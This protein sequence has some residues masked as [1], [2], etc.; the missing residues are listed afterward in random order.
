MRSKFIYIIIFLALLLCSCEKLYFQEVSNDPE[1]VFE[2]FWNEVDQNFSFFSYLNLNWDSIHTVYRPK[3][4]LNTPPKELAQILG[5]MIKLLKDGHSDLFTNYG[6]FSYTAWYSN[7]PENKLSSNSSYF[8]YYKTDNNNIYYGK[9]KSANL[10]YIYIKSFGGND[11]LQYTQIDMILNNFIDADGIIIDVRSNTGGNSYNGTCISRRF[12]DSLRFVHKTRFRNGNKHNDFTPWH[13]NYLTPS[14]VVHY[15]K[16]IAVLTNRKCFSATSWFILEM[17]SLPQV[18]II[19]DTTGGGSAQPIVR[20]LSNGWI[21][22]V[23]NSQRLS[24]EGK[25]DQYTGLYPDIPVWISEQDVKDGID[26]ILERAIKE[27]TKK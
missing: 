26:A 21:V 11:T 12:A 22:R 23:S 5:Q 27:L 14:G 19:G 24:P 9:I 4:N 13:S 15:K 2:C 10:G 7:Y 18:T 8:D 3:V 16:P 20:E 17:R 6:S 25:D 1:S